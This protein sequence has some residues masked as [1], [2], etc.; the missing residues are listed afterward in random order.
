MKRK[1]VLSDV[2]IGT[3]SGFLDL[4]FVVHF[5]NYVIL[6]WKTLDFTSFLTLIRVGLVI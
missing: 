1:Y 2:L 4:L 5:R 6:T 3:L